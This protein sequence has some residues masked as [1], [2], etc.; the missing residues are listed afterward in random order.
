[1]SFV[2]AI[3]ISEMTITVKNAKSIFNLS[4]I[5]CKI[6]FG[7]HMKRNIN[8]F[9]NLTIEKTQN[10][11]NGQVNDMLAIYKNTV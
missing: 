6:S 4:R 9:K 5:C 1:M 10:G 11:I 3:I 8:E 2:V 7:S